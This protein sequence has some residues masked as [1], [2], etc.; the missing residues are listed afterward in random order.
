[1]LDCNVPLLLKIL[2]SSIQA[3]DSEAGG[4]ILLWVIAIEASRLSTSGEEAPQPLYMTL[5]V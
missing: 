3:E 4:G 2:V 1:L 5:Q